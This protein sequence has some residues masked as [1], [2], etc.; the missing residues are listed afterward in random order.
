MIELILLITAL[1][2]ILLI[3]TIQIPVPVPQKPTYSVIEECPDVQGEHW[4]PIFKE[5]NEHARP[6]THQ[7]IYKLFRNVPKDA[8][9]ARERTYC[10]G[11]VK[12]LSKEKFELLDI[13]NLD[14][15]AEDENCPVVALMD[16][17]VKVADSTEVIRVIMMW[18][19]NDLWTIH[20]ANAK[21]CY[22]PGNQ[23]ECTVS[24]GVVSNKPIQMPQFHIN[25]SLMSRKQ[26]FKWDKTGVLETEP[27]TDDSPMI[28]SAWTQRPSEVFQNPTMP[29]S[30]SPMNQNEKMFLKTF[31]VPR[32]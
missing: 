11:A 14:W 17:R 9:T 5:M 4:K 13:D 19:N 7:P 22:R 32:S 10:K 20:P 28:N 26:E 30:P 16:A 18:S 24:I 1:L 2:I 21:G 29:S 27:E 3:F 8:I 15:M 12:N 25:K 31:G 6:P 23:Y